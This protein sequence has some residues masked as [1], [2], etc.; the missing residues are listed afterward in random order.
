MKERRAIE[1]WILRSKRKRRSLPRREEA[2]KITE[3]QNGRDRYVGGEAVPRRGNSKW[4]EKEKNEKYRNTG[5]RDTGFV[6]YL[7]S[8]PGISYSWIMLVLVLKENVHG[9]LRIPYYMFSFVV[10]VRMVL[11]VKGN[12]KRRYYQALAIYIGRPKNIYRYFR[13]GQKKG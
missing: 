7:S 13:G 2:P 1:P 4:S 6:V 8:G 11:R 3:E 9:Y 12:R 10:G 5:I